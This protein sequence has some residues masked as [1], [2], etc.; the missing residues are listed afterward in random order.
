MG[1]KPT[2]GLVSRSGIIPISF[3]QDTAGPMGRTVEDVAICLGVLAGVD[4][5]DAKT[6]AAPGNIHGDYAQFLKAD[7]LDG[8]RI[9]LLKGSA[10]YHHKVAALLEQAAAFLKS[11][12]ATVVEVEGPKEGPIENDSFQVMLYE[13]KDGLEQVL[14]RPGADPRRRKTSRS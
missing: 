8:K 14:R 4:E 5:T 11:R 9:G 12:G 6:L 7:G 13:F 3:T 2:V 10:G 1:L